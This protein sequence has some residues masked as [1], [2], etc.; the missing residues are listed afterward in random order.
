MFVF[1]FQTDGLRQRGMEQPAQETLLLPKAC[2][3]WTYS[4]LTGTKQSQRQSPFVQPCDRT[5]SVR[6][7]K[8]SNYVTRWTSREDQEPQG[9]PIMK[10]SISGGSPSGLLLVLMCCPLLGLVHSASSSNKASDNGHAHLGDADPDRCMRHHFVETITH[11]IYKC[12]SK[13]NLPTH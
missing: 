6:R 3:I 2:W 13:V 10:P 1:C 7:R 12:N 8:K 11:P 5:D 9:G 4:E